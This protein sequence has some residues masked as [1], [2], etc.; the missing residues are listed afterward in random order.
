VLPRRTG[1]VGMRWRGLDKQVATRQRGAEMLT[2]RVCCCIQPTFESSRSR[3]P[4]LQIVHSPQPGVSG[5][6]PGNPHHDWRFGRRLAARRR[7]RRSGMAPVCGGYG[8]ASGFSW[9]KPAPRLV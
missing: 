2:K 4:W 3:K 7:G 5:L 9:A 6:R 8:R 1:T